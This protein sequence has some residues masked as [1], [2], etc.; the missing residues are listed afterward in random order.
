ML[1]LDGDDSGERL[2]ELYEKLQLL[3]ADAA[4]AQ[5]SKILA[6][7]DFTNDMQ[8]RPTKSFSGG[9]RMRISL[10]RALFIQPT[11]LLLLDEPTNHLDLSAVRWLKEYLCRW[12]KTLIVVSHDRGFLN[13]VCNEI[14]HLH[15]MKLH[16]YRGNFD[17]FERGYEQRRKEKNKEFEKYDKQLNAAKRLCNQI[18]QKKVQEKA[19]FTQEKKSI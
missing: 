3:G 10:A 14:I 6:G 9:W 16:M 8:V 19:K 18:Q 2:A 12:G 4:E 1:N 13:T 7:L 15:D 11:T 17:E 5:A